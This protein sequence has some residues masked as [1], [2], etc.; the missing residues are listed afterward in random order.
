M[1][2]TAPRDA[3]SLP[4]VV[5]ASDKAR[6]DLLSPHEQPAIH[7]NLHRL[8]LQ[9]SRE[10]PPRTSEVDR[11]DLKSKAIGALRRLQ[12]MPDLVRSFFLHPCLSYI[13]G[14]WSDSIFTVY[15]LD[16]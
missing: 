10:A 15:K 4:V 5:A 1:A 11:D 6:D 12:N 2:D 14:L 8:R 13:I 9:R 7:D 16:S 3:S